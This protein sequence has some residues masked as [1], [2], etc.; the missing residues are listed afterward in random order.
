MWGRVFS[1]A[2]SSSERTSLM[3]FTFIMLV[4][5]SGSFSELG[6]CYASFYNAIYSIQ[7]PST[8]FGSLLKKFTLFSLQKDFVC[9]IATFTYMACL[10]VST[11]GAMFVKLLRSRN[12]GGLIAS[13]LHVHLSYLTFFCLALSLSLALSK[14]AFVDCSST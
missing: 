14:L 7:S 11:V 1:L 13:I 9:P 12:K 4:V 5:L 10:S 2:F 6:L 3:M 8:I